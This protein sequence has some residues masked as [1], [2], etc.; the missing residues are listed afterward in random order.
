[1]TDRTSSSITINA[2]KSKV[3][4]AIADF[5]AYP[6]WAEGIKAAEVVSAGDGY[7][8]E[9]VRFNLS[10][11]PMTDTYVLAYEWEGDDAV[12]WDI[13]E[14]GK[15]I[16]SMSGSYRLADR[17]GGTEVTYELAVEASLLRIGIM[18]RKTEKMIVDTGLKDLKRRVEG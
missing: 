2:G 14:P 1:M 15:M 5:P 8:A 3:M 16:S 4:A 17:D 7:R 9:R 10:A 6:T 18:K 12:R 11:G 13:S